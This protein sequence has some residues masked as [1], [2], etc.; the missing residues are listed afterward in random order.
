MLYGVAPTDPLT[1]GSVAALLMLVA[2]AAAMVPAAR[3]SG[4]QPVKALRA[5]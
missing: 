3:A 4:I 1:F 5:E 2:I